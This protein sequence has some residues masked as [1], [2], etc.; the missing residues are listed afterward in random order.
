VKRGR[1][2]R[3]RPTVLYIDDDRFLLTLCCDVLEGHGYRTLIA[4]DGPSG[5][6]TAK[7]GRPDVILLD[8]FMPGM[9]GLQVCRHLR[10]VPD[11]RGTPII[12]L[13]ARQDL[14]LDAEGLDAGA[15]LTLR[16]G[17]SSVELLSAIDRLLGR[18][19]GPPPR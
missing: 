8:V 18:N 16:K 1:R 4:T 17:F 7:Q 15:T 2:V 6:E 10:A 19:P 3:T 11:L 12:L 14:K 9:D 5:I 13:T